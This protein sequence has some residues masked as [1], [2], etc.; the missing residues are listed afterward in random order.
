M[1]T[2]S[3]IK[4]GKADAYELPRIMVDTFIDELRHALKTGQIDA[5]EITGPNGEILDLI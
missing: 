2:V 3:Y 5:V 1:C 4:D